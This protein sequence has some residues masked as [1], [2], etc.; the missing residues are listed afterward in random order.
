[1]A[2][3]EGKR[4]LRT[5]LA[6]KIGAG[7]RGEVWRAMREGAIELLPATLTDPE[8]PRFDREARV[9]ASM[10]PPRRARSCG[11]RAPDGIRCVAVD[12]VTGSQ[13]AQ[14]GDESDIRMAERAPSKPT[15]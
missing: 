5:I 11:T 4:L 13:L 7:G 14:V 9:P 10:D 15:P 6:G 1:V 12:R 3:S 8:R 2:P